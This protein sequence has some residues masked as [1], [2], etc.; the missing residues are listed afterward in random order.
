MS[1][2]KTLQEKDAKEEKK[3]IFNRFSKEVSEDIIAV[4]V[5][6]D[7]VSRSTNMDDI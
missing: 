5:E 2:T 4:A 6:D 7:P 3:G 1:I